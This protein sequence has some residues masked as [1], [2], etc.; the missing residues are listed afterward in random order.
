M[1]Q[2]HTKRLV[3]GMKVSDVAD[4]DHRRYVSLASVGNSTS[5]TFL[6][7]PLLTSLATYCRLCIQT[8]KALYQFVQLKVFAIG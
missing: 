4:P 2:V 8:L 1:F 3:K 6:V 7:V 5:M